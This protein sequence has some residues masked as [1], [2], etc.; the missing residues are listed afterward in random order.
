MFIVISGLGPNGH[1]IHGLILLFAWCG[2]IEA[3]AILFFL[4]ENGE[5]SLINPKR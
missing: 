5:I 2:W 1:Q 3:R 4:R